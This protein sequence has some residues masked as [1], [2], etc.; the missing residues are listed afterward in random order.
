MILQKLALLQPLHIGGAVVAPADAVFDLT[1]IF[2]H[3]LF[4]HAKGLVA[5]DNQPL[6]IARRGGDYSR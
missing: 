2:A 4:A 3:L 6:A 5:I 1:I